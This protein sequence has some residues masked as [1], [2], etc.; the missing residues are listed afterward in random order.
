M[1][2]TFNNCLVFDECVQKV[3]EARLKVSAISEAT[4]LNLVVSEETGKVFSVPADDNSTDGPYER[5]PI[6]FEVCCQEPVFRPRLIKDKIVNCGWVRG[7]LIIKNAKTGVT[8]ECLP[9]S[10]V[11]QEV[12]LAC[13]VLPTDTITEFVAEKEGEVTCVVFET[14]P[15]TAEEP[16]A[17]VV[18]KCIFRVRKIV[19]REEI[20]LPDPCTGGPVCPDPCEADTACKKHR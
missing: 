10:L 19:T 17:I 12:Q 20:V 3:A 11:F 9:V 7:T 16:V 18:M 2:I 1:G 6:K 5:I 14:L 8:I 4:E 15:D 13:G